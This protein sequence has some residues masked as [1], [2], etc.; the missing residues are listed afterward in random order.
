MMVQF[1]RTL[2]Y[3]T[4]QVF[5]QTGRASLSANNVLHKNELLTTSHAPT[6]QILT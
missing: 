2:L 6:V 3:V 5:T 4:E 1:E